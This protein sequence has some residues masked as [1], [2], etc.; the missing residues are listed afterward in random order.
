MFITKNLKCFWIVYQVQKL[1]NEQAE[2]MTLFYMLR[3]HV[4]NEVDESWVRRGGEE[5]HLH[6]RQL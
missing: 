3:S 2:V 5:V 1:L 4:L 6:M